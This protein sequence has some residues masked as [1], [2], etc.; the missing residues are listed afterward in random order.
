[1]DLASSLIFLQHQVALTAGEMLR[2][3]TK[4]EQQTAQFGV[5]SEKYHAYVPFGSASLQQNVK[6]IGQM[7]NFS[8]T[9]AHH[10]N[11]VAECAIQTVTRWARTM[12]LHALIMWPDQADL[13]LWPFYYGACSVCL[14]LPAKARQPNCAT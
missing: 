2:S 5:A 3:M 8:G 14:E 1:M 13:T 10:Q 7:I 11:G 12:F 4:F 9:G 6:D